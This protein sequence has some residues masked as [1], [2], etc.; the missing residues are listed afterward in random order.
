MAITVFVGLIAVNRTSKAGSAMPVDVQVPIEMR[1]CQSDGDCTFVETACS[2]CCVYAGIN[3]RHEK[4]FYDVTYRTGC[5]AYKGAVC[6]C[7]IPSAK[8]LC[9][10]GLC[11]ITTRTGMQCRAE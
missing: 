4:T 5:G 1:A 11:T 3:V 6:D 7:Y 8:A 2:A 10:E 9:I